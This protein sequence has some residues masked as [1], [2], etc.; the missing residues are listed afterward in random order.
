MDKEKLIIALLIITI[1]LSVVSV[2]ITL[3]ANLDFLKPK[4][5][6]NIEED[7]G[8]GTIGFEIISPEGGTE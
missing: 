4:Q 3:N 2:V 6:I 8:F 7:R 1:I 5:I